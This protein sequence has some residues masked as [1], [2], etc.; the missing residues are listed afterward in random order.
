MVKEI[1]PGEWAT[2]GEEKQRPSALGASC[3]AALCVARHGQKGAERTPNAW[4]A[5]R[6]AASVLICLGAGQV[7]SKVVATPADAAQC[8]VDVGVELPSRGDSEFTHPHETEKGQ[9]EGGREHTAVV[10]TN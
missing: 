1:Q 10:P 8:G 3:Y 2:G 6:V 4:D 9:R 5:K 7:V